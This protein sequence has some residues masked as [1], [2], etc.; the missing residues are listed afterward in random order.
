MATVTTKQ[1]DP[2]LPDEVDFSGGVRGRHLPKDPAERAQ[3]L[4]ARVKVLQEYG[5]RL[6]Q[7]AERVYES[8]SPESAG[9]Y[10]VSRDALD[11]LH[12]VLFGE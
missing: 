8:A 12:K 3:R 9:Q 11:A 4:A 2:D 10:R 7:A 5:A 1:H 6:R